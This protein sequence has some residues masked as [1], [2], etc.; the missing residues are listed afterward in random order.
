MAKTEKIKHPIDDTQWIDVDTLKANSYN[1]NYVL[2]PEF[3]LLK[4]LILKYKWIQ[5]I[6]ITKDNV[7]IDGFH[8]H[9]LAKTDPEVRALTDGKVPCSVMDI[10]E[11]QRKMLT[12]SINR[13]KGVH[14]AVK[15]HELVGS[16]V[17]DH[18][19][20]I[21]EICEG[22]GATKDEIDLL[23]KENVF[24]KMDIENHDYSEAWNVKPGA[25]K[26]NTDTTKAHEKAATE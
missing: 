12:V 24:K 20:P 13:A 19:L 14:S 17:N 10:D 22:I 6:L 26:K 1:P 2:G 4:A 11:A 16:L 5:P 15:M 25:K 3:K 7:I 8:R 9:M 18:K 23:L 21:K